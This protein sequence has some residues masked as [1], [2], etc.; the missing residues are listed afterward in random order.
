M[1]PLRCTAA[2]SSDAPAALSSGSSDGPSEEF[3]DDVDESARGSGESETNGDIGIIL[4][5]G[6]DISADSQVSWLD[7]SVLV[8]AVEYLRHA[9][10]GLLLCAV[11][12]LTIL[13]S[14][15]VRTARRFLEGAATGLGRVFSYGRWA[16]SAPEV[17]VEPL[18]SWVGADCSLF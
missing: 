2:W 5:P 8:Q 1:A 17:A 10:L 13:L 18:L 15:A 6:I 14:L 9:S 3:L 7:V 11:N 12:S 16:S 4:E